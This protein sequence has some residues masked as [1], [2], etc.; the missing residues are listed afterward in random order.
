MKRNDFRDPFG[1]EESQ[2]R[3][4]IAHV[5]HEGPLTT[6]QDSGDRVTLT[7][8]EDADSQWIRH[9]YVPDQWAGSRVLEAN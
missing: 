8:V 4:G 3:V 2:D 5:D 1:F 7:D 6:R 9:A